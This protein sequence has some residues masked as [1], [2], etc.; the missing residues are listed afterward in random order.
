MYT[1]TL[2]F[3]H[4]K[5]AKQ[6]VCRKLHIHSHAQMPQTDEQG[7]AQ[8]LHQKLHTFN[9]STYLPQQSSYIRYAISCTHSPPWWRRDP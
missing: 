4:L 5:A 9:P 8:Q 3:I 6:N 2:L 1:F 7:R